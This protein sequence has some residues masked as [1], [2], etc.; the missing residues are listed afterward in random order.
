MYKCKTCEKAKINTPLASWTSVSSWENLSTRMREHLGLIK[1]RS[2][3]GDKHRDAV[4]KLEKK[5]NFYV[6]REFGKKKIVKSLEESAS[7]TYTFKEIQ[8]GVILKIAFFTAENA[9][10][11]NTF[12]KLRDWLRTMIEYFRYNPSAEIERM[13]GR[14]SKLIDGI[15]KIKDQDELKLEL[16]GKKSFLTF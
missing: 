4:E 2:E 7:E 6:H 5:T 16:K 14:I 1:S 10:S 9:L 15:Y 11:I 8:A 3:R 13:N 12:F